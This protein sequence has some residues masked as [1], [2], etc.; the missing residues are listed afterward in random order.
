M[1]VAGVVQLVERFLAKEKV[2]SSSLV[3]QVTYVDAD[4]TTNTTLA[5]GSAFVPKLDNGVDKDLA[6][7]VLYEPIDPNGECSAK[8][9][10]GAT[11]W[12]LDATDSPSGA[13]LLWS[14]D[15]GDIDAAATFDGMAKTG[16]FVGTNAG[17]IYRL[18]A[19]DGSSCWG[20][21]ADGCGS[22]T[23]SEEFFCT[24]PAVEARAT[25][26]ASTAATSSNGWTRLR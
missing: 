17:R 13:R 22:A 12:A 7:L 1:S 3:A 25:S 5:D 9:G 10:S 14:R 16:L 8:L 4:P 2:T 11:L 20:S 15:L 18:T 24:D 21:T 26:C 19:T 23:G 6:S